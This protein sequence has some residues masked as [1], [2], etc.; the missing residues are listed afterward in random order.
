MTQKSRS[1]AATGSRDRCSIGSCGGTP[2]AARGQHPQRRAQTRTG[3][4]DTSGRT[5][6]KSRWSHVLFFSRLRTNRR[7]CLVGQQ[8]KEGDTLCIIE[9]MKIM[10]EIKA[11]CDG[12][13][14]RLWHGGV[15]WSITESLCY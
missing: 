15:W 1:S 3:G 6:V 13:I 4:E 14:I 11:P 5:Q 2:A 10:N 7:S 12:K 9:A 8:V